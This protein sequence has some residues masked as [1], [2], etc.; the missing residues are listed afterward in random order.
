MKKQGLVSKIAIAA[1]LVGAIASPSPQAQAPTEAVPVAPAQQQQQDKQAIPVKMTRR[2]RK[3]RRESD[4]FSGLNPELRDKMRK[5]KGRRKGRGSLDT[6]DSWDGY[7]WRMRQR[8][9]K[10]KANKERMLRWGR[11]T[12]A[13]LR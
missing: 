9:A 7:V 10:A 5:S 8:V 12:A 13:A 4:R 11:E 1:G 6:S 2:N 3:Q